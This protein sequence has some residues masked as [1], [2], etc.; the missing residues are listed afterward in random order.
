M[1][2]ELCSTTLGIGDAEEVL[3]HTASWVTCEQRLRL[4]RCYS[5]PMS[6]AY[7]C[8]REL[9]GYVYLHR[10]WSRLVNTSIGSI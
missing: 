6:G 8:H 5:V 1:A 2:L 9:A 7:L 10:L 4:E 3:Q